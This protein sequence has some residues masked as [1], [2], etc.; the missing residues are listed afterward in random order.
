MAAIKNTIVLIKTDPL[1]M[2]FMKASSCMKVMR[3][4]FD[5]FISEHAGKVKAG[6]LERY[7]I[8]GC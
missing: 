3:S 1:I 8:S 5:V 2:V 7:L 4:W 6:L